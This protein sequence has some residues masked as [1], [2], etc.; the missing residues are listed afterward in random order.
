MVETCAI[1][2]NLWFSQLPVV[3]KWVFP[4][5]PCIYLDL[6]SLSGACVYKMPYFSKISTSM[7]INVCR[8][9]L[10]FQKF[11]FYQ[12][13]PIHVTFD[14][15]LYPRPFPKHWLLILNDLFFY[16]GKRR[17]SQYGRVCLCNRLS[18]MSVCV[19]VCVPA[20]GVLMEA[21][22]TSWLGLFHWTRLLD[23]AWTK[24]ETSAPRVAADASL[25]K[26]SYSPHTNPTH[27]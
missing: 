21:G 26:E 12:T 9:M 6:T 5:Q 1:Q 27:I 18:R 22:E 24:M 7:E 13:E 15:V 10:P 23:Q 4:R 19:L 14:R 11:V 16:I 25:E 17:I 20:D 3:Q 8:C 2:E